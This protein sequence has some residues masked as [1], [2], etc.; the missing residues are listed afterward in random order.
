MI[1]LLNTGQSYRDLGKEL[2]DFVSESKL[3]ANKESQE[4]STLFSSSSWSIGASTSPIKDL[5]SGNFSTIDNA[6]EIAAIYYNDTLIFYNYTSNSI[7][8]RFLLNDADNAFS[9][10]LYYVIEYNSSLGRVW[11]YNASASIVFDTIENGEII[12]SDL[13]GDKLIDFV[14]WNSTKAE[15][16]FAN[17]TTIISKTIDY[18][19][20]TSD[21]AAVLVGPVEALET[22][23]LR[24]GTEL[25]INLIGSTA[26]YSCLFKISAS[27]VNYTIFYTTSLVGVSISTAIIIDLDFNDYYLDVLVFKTND[28]DQFLLS[29]KLLSFRNNTVLMDYSQ[30]KTISFNVDESFRL[31]LY[32]RGENYGSF[33][34]RD[35]N[36]PRNL[37]F[38]F[39][40]NLY[41][42]SFNLDRIYTLDV[43]HFGGVMDDLLLFDSGK[44]YFQIIL[45]EKLVNGDSSPLVMN[46]ITDVLSYVIYDM[47][48]DGLDDLIIGENGYIVFHKAPQFGVSYFD[49]QP[50]GYVYLVK[51]TFINLDNI[52]DYLIAYTD[53]SMT[54]FYIYPFISDSI[55]PVI[56]FINLYPENPTARDSIVIYV[57]TT[58]NLYISYVVARY[59]VYVLGSVFYS[60]DIIILTKGPEGLYYATLPPPQIFDILLGF[61]IRIDIYVSD[62]FGN[63]AY[64]VI[65]KDILS[66]PDYYTYHDLGESL[67]GIKMLY[68]FQLIDSDQDN[69]TEIYLLFSTSEINSLGYDHFLYYGDYGSPSYSFYN[70]SLDTSLLGKPVRLH[71]LYN[72]SDYLILITYENAL[73]IYSSDLTLI[74]RK[75]YATFAKAIESNLFDYDSD[76]CAELF[77]I[78]DNKTLQI[79]NLSNNELSIEKIYSMN[80]FLN[81]TMLDASRNL[82]YGVYVNSTH[83]VV[84]YL[85]LTS[86][87]QFNLSYY[88]TLPSYAENRRI[89]GLFNNRIFLALSNGTLL[90]F[91]YSAINKINLP[92]ELSDSQGFESWSIYGNDCLIV[93]DSVGQVFFINSSLVIYN[94]IRVPLGALPLSIEYGDTDRDDLSE[95]VITYFENYLNII[96]LDTRSN[97]SLVTF[98]MAYVF[99]RDFDNYTGNDL[100]YLMRNGFMLVND[101][102]KYYT[103]LLELVNNTADIAQGDH[104]YAEITLKDLFGNPINDATVEAE[105][106]TPRGI[107]IIQTLTNVGT[108]RYVLDIATDGWGY[109]LASVNIIIT[110]N[111]YVGSNTSFKVLIR[112]ILKIISDD[113]FYVTHGSDLV[114]RFDVRDIFGDKVGG[115]EGNIT[116]SNITAE[117]YY[118]STSEMYE[119]TFNSGELL[120]LK[121]GEYE[122]IINITHPLAQDYFT[123]IIT[124]DIYSQLTLIAEI[125]PQII[126]QGDSFNV[127]IQVYDAGGHRV[128]DADVYF[129]VNDE[130]YWGYSVTVHTDGWVKGN[131]TITIYGDHV[132][133]YY[134]AKLVKWVIVY[135]IP[136]VYFNY[137]YVDAGVDEVTIEVRD[138]YYNLLT[139]VNVNISIE[140]GI[141]ITVPGSGIYRSEINFTE[142]IRK[143]LFNITIHVY[144]GSYVRERVY[145]PYTIDIKLNVYVNVS[146]TGENGSEYIFQG[147][148]VN[149]DI[150]VYDQF[151]NPDDWIWGVEVEI[152]G[153][154][155][156]PEQADVGNFSLVLSMDNARYGIYEVVIWIYTDTHIN[157]YITKSVELILL[158]DIQ[159]DYYEINYDNAT[160]ILKLYFYDKY[161]YSIDEANITSISCTPLSIINITRGL[162]E[163][164]I[165][166]NGT[167]LY[168]G[169]YDILLNVSWSLAR[170]N[171]EVNKTYY[172][173]ISIY[174]PLSADIYLSPNESIIQGEEILLNVSVRTIYGVEIHDAF[175][176]A[177]LGNTIVYPVYVDGFY[178]SSIETSGFGYGDYEI[179]IYV[180]HDYG[181]STLIV[182]KDVR[183][184][185]VPYISLN[186][187]NLGNKT[188]ILHIDVR[189]LYG[190]AFSQ[191]EVKLEIGGYR[192]SGFIA[193]G[194]ATITLN[195]KSFET[196][197]YEAILIVSG[198][199]II[200]SSFVVRVNVISYVS[201]DNI[202]LSIPGL[203]NTTNDY[204]DDAVV[205]GD[206]IYL[207]ISVYDIYN[208][209]F[210][211]CQ[212]IVIFAGVQY[213][214][215]EISGNFFAF[216]IPTENM[217]SGHYT[218]FI[219]ISSTYLRSDSGNMLA[220]ERLVYI[221]PEIHYEILVQESVIEGQNLTIYIRLFDKYG[222]PLEP[223]ENMTSIIVRVNYQEYIANWNED[224]HTYIVSLIAPTV[225]KEHVS[226]VLRIEILI[227]YGKAVEVREE[228]TISVMATSPITEQQI[229]SLTSYIYVITLVLTIAIVSAYLIIRINTFNERLIKLFYRLIL[230][231]QISLTITTGIMLLVNNFEMAA[232]TM[233]ILFLSIFAL[234]G[235]QLR[236]D[237]VK[238]VRVAYRMIMNEEEKIRVKYNLI[239]YLL[240]Y[241]I[242]AI[243]ILVMFEYIGSNIIWFSRFILGEYRTLGFIHDITL[244]TIAFYLFAARGMILYTRRHF[245]DLLRNKLPAI[246]Y[247]ENIEARLTIF[248]N[249]VE[250]SLRT[251]GSSTL[252]IT[253]YTLYLIGTYIWGASRLTMLRINP[254]SLI[255]LLIPLTVPI[256]IIWILHFIK[257]PWEKKQ[258]RVVIT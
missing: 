145:G 221:K 209:S 127:T 112:P 232:F 122:A 115:V 212:V 141:N 22:N 256:A 98:D 93:A 222:N 121:L 60:I 62:I 90:F 182:S 54:Y 205:Q 239:R 95:L 245:N 207:N 3:S 210:T 4:Q 154:V 174:A 240:I 1:V 58:D 139:D 177:S 159:I 26:F 6:Y 161:G 136:V 181:A 51:R 92:S 36:D 17:S 72:G 149:I 135:A 175:V 64:Q 250:D 218:I 74:D 52:Y 27:W 102:S 129:I 186:Q 179:E 185:G 89:L 34:V 35:A 123:R 32:N 28:F 244:V 75:F 134:P 126:N 170:Y 150:Y 124:I 82:L 247:A 148:L 147:E 117:I 195:L 241:A 249:L 233:L 111:Y 132:Y 67:S 2:N 77:I 96:N 47:D 254:I 86:G 65:E 257:L 109:G 9:G 107:T 68:G 78:F 10:N 226:E 166:F 248:S 169:E 66:Y 213:Y 130:E 31:R 57:N 165:T 194:S 153:V 131:Y 12:S 140:N 235:I 146:I 33:I 229:T 43:G 71:S 42:F 167:L 40:S 97:A 216:K 88:D 37:Y 208:V 190:N 201:E 224:S 155:Y 14:I 21:A 171:I 63:Y 200:N 228:V 30:T 192:Y 15:I 215:Y 242:G 251:M 231:L 69:K 151:G 50:D 133:V 108:G 76:G 116:I 85:N 152:E 238:I 164:S 81:D 173:S 255:L 46:T 246:T 94:S 56:H 113:Y 39:T 101:L 99:L 61:N 118:N 206:D 8:N 13:D 44:Y 219:Q 11:F 100:L 59:T 211:K 223:I 104:V 237:Q 162:G 45:G 106:K 196:G 252:S 103:V 199:Y 80:L 73:E 5:Y 227:S 243:T 220:F 178:I 38:F 70:V 114:I 7:L 193:D 91:N 203:A 187:D 105:I 180:Y 197:S 138:I 184:I 83:T 198:D 160:T 23:L 128:T 236:H 143:K 49:G 119:A 183:I 217:M 55:A 168:P 84:S 202:Y 79:L 120:N 53:E 157:E 18:V 189:D 41:E 234:Y 163:S 142:Y 24:S 25:V 191:G 214:P 16:F 158:P 144:N 172:L 110:H 156:Y 225:G 230:I 176:V 253:I 48:H 258:E 188:T 204:P 137:T 87:Q 29:R 20:I 125:T 19:D